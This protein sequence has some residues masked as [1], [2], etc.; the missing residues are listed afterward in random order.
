VSANASD[1]VGVAGVQFKLD[2]V[3]LAA[4]TLSSPYAGRVER[5]GGVRG[6]TLTA[7]ARD[8]A[9]N[10]RTSAGV[11]V[12]VAASRRRADR[13]GRTNQPDLSP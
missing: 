11:S 2:G 6:P 13:R 5:L 1:N 9:G 4:E 7:V 8:A 10:T 12:T 3:N